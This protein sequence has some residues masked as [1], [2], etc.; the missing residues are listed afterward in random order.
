MLQPGTGPCGRFSAEGAGALNAQSCAMRRRIPGLKFGQRSPPRSWSAAQRCSQH[1]RSGLIR[2]E[3][4]V[5]L[6]LASPSLPPF[7]ATR[8]LV[9][10]VLGCCGRRGCHWLCLSSKA[11]GIMPT[12]ARSLA[13]YGEL[14]RGSQTIMLSICSIERLFIQLA[15]ACICVLPR[16]QLAS[17]RRQP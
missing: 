9:G 14:G 17:H 3:S 8:A 1:D 16:R 11:C 2:R 7:P 15:R 10:G 4:D 6:A 5:Q 12:V 13:R